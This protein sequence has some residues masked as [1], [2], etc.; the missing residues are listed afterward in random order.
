MFKKIL[1]LS[2]LLSTFVGQAQQLDHVLGEVII[3]FH[4]ELAKPDAFLKQYKRFKGKSTQITAKK[5]LNPSMNIWLLRFDHTKINE[6]HLLQDLNNNKLVQVVQRNHIIKTRRIPNDPLFNSQWNLRNTGGINGQIDADIDAELAWDIT[7]G[8][9]TPEGDTIVIAVVDD[10]VDLDHPDLK[11]NLWKNYAEIP[12]N[13]VDDDNNGYIDDYDGWNVNTDSDNVDNTAQVN[14]SHG[15]EVSGFIGAIGN[16]GSGITGINWSIKLMILSPFGIG[17]D[18][19]ASAIEAYS[20]VLAMRKAYNESNGTRGAYVVATNSSWG[21]DGQME[22][23]APLWCAFYTRLGEE[24]IINT[25]ATV[26]QNINIDVEGDLPTTCTSD[27]IIGVTNSTNRDDAA[28]AGYG[29]KSVDLSA[30]AENVPILL[31]DGGT[32]NNGRG[33]S[34]AAPQVAGVVGL[35]YA[36]PCSNFS[37]LSKQDPAFAAQLV[38]GYIL[39]GVDVN[40]NFSGLTLTSGRLNAH[41][42]LQLL[43]ADCESCPPP[44]NV[45]LS[46]NSLQSISLEW[47]IAN[48][49][50]VILRYRESGQNNWTTINSLQSPSTIVG[51]KQCTD[52]EV[53]LSG[54]CSGESPNYSSSF[55]IKTNGCCDPPN[56]IQVIATTT[57]SMQIQWEEVITANNYAIQWRLQGSNTWTDNNNSTNTLTIDGLSACTNYELRVKPD[58]PNRTTVFSDPIIITTKGCG[59]C[60]DVEYC[61]AKGSDSFLEWIQSV[62]LNDLDNDSGNNSGY[63]DYTNFSTTLSTYASYDLTV[64]AGYQSSRYDEFFKVWIDYDHSGTFEEA[65]ETVYDSEVGR[66]NGFTTSIS[67]PETAKLGST[68]MRVAMK[69]SESN[70]N[71][72]PKA[73]EAFEFGEVED[74]CVNIVEGTYKCLSPIVSLLEVTNSSAVASLVEIDSATIYRIRYRPTEG[75]NWTA[76]RFDVGQAYVI[77]NLLPCVNYQFQF[78]SICADGTRSPYSASYTRATPCDCTAPYDL[79]TQVI[80]ESTIELSWSGMADVYEVFFASLDGSFLRT[81]AV[82]EKKITIEDIV[83]C[84][85]YDLNITSICLEER[86]EFLETR[87]NSCTTSIPNIPKEL[88]QLTVSPNPFQDRLQIDFLLTATSDLTIGFY[89]I[90]GQLLQEQVYANLLI[91]QQRQVLDLPNVTGGVYLVKVATD[92]GLLLKRVVKVN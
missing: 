64:R 9:L 88:D 7:T 43:L 21:V 62:Q 49:N 28:I 13:G 48:A 36:A 59:V 19:E 74:Y 23:D 76:E 60:V 68:R 20:Y 44:L 22:S 82:S 10:G 81:W 71:L 4:P 1:F 26:N 57:T 79:S 47:A 61:E 80:N 3:Q 24:G 32:K 66:R 56:D 34:Y 87:V 42:S 46:S 90:N 53:Q 83:A 27:Y 30:P 16:N 89:S 51:L 84:Q 5:C 31:K 50:K 40:S 65:T 25:V 86:G 33:A 35:L 17:T 75:G 8:G 45:Q 29:P 41:N 55:Q 37:Q 39:N 15:T 73:C 85:D 72:S 11:G 77:N 2:F 6:Y 58:C 14:A 52:Y 91:G 54:D 69:A 67:I 70:T 38:K 12:N 92:S 63:G 18:N 78:S